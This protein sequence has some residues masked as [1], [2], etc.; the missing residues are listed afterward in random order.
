MLVRLLTSDLRSVID[1]YVAAWRRGDADAV[2]A[3]FAPD[4]V[5]LPHD[6]VA[7]RVG[8][9]A[10]RAFWFPATRAPTGIDEFTFDIRDIAERG[11]TTVAW[12]ARRLV[13]WS[14]LEGRR[15]TYTFNGTFLIVL[16]RRGS[17][18]LITHFMWDDPA[19]QVS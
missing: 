6:G 15:T 16:G 4:A 19:P 7:P 10:L 12:G 1:M 3:L 2:L 5:I 14:E 17:S 11:D 8:R 18:W 9:D 13:Y